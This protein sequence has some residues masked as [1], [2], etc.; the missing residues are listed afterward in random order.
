MSEETEPPTTTDAMTE[1]DKGRCAPAPG[2]AIALYKTTG[3]RL[4]DHCLVLYLA[5]DRDWGSRQLERN[6]SRWP[7]LARTQMTPQ[8]MEYRNMRH[9]A[10]SLRYNGAR[11]ADA[12]GLGED[13][14]DLGFDEATVTRFLDAAKPYWPNPELRHAGRMTSSAIAELET[15]SRVAWSDLIGGF[16]DS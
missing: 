11:P 7:A 2:S 1:Q 10:S 15:P 3:N 5:V 12:A 4:K 16:M 8:A 6:G 14:R 13:L 9:R